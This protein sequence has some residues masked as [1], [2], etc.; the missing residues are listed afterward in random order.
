M[1]VFPEVGSTRVDLPGAMSPRLSASS[2]IDRAMRSLTLFAGL[3]DSS[4]A[5]ISAPQSF[6]TLF[7]LTRGVLPINSRM[8]E[9]ILGRAPTTFGGA[10]DES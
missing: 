10:V 7:S 4:L 8:L 6:V 5:T 3:D 1:P 9:A 2:I